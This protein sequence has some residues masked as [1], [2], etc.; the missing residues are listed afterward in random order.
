MVAV[1]L[2]EI[3]V[4]LLVQFV[5]LSVSAD[6]NPPGKKAASPRCYAGEQPLLSWETLILASKVYVVRAPGTQFVASQW[7]RERVAKLS[8]KTQ[9]KTKRTIFGTYLKFKFNWASCLI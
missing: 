4:S 6:E 9:N 2:L 5:C 8:H 3:P 7:I 1:G